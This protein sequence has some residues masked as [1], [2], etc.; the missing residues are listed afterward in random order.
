MFKVYIQIYT[1]IYV[2]VSL[3]GHNLGTFNAR[4]LKFDMLLRQT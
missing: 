2:S 4:K 1:D 3:R